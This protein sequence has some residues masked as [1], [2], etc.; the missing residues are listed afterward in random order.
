M[1]D[2]QAPHEHTPVQVP[3][4]ETPGLSGLL[5]LAGFVVVVAGLYVGREVLIP[6]TLAIL[7][8]FLIAPLA[9]L[10]RRAHFGRVP[11]VL[12]AVVLALGVIVVL[13]GLIGAQFA[14]LAEQV[15]QYESTIV[16]KVREVR[17]FA[18][19][20]MAGIADRVG[21]QLQLVTNDQTTGSRTGPAAAPAAPKPLAVQVQQAALSPIDIARSILGPVISPLSTTLIVLI[22]SVFILLQREDLRNRLIRVFGSGDLHRTTLAIDDAAGRLSRYFL[23]QVGINTIFGVVIGAGLAVIGVP[24]PLL[25]GTLSMLLRFLPY[26][27]SPLSSVG[28]LLLAA[29][30]EPNW[31]MVIWTAALYSGV[32]IVTS[33][34]VEPMVYGRSTGL[35]P[36]A[37]VVA[38]TFWTWLWGPI[39][40][41]LSTP[42]TLCLVVLGRHVKRLEFLD[43]LLGDRP[44][45]SS[46]ESFYQRI[47]AGDPDEA[48]DQ[49]EI[50]LKSCSLS[51]YYDEVVLKGLQMAA[52]DAAR[53]A[54]SGQQL[55]QVKVS[56]EELVQDLDR[57]DDVDPS[58]V[59]EEVAVSPLGEP[60]Q[61]DVPKSGTIQDEDPPSGWRSDSAVLCIAGRGP[62]DEGVATMLAQLLAKH[63]LGARM[64]PFAAVTRDHIGALAV[65]GVKMVCVSYLEISGSPA[66]LR[67][68]LH[69]LRAKVPNVPIMVGLWP[70]EELVLREERVR[71]IIGAEYYTSTLR[72]AVEACLSASKGK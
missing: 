30:V 60:K 66:H 15:P 38:A 3:P 65:S 67:Y 24:S 54:L 17:S 49:A 55:E 8:S 36:F 21:R 33:Q 70:S 57:H 20:E 28:P 58:P 59:A 64:V 39:G 18:L 48:L 11:S 56:I 45:L 51:S 41:L 2:I 5:T 37:V 69:R 1:P 46:I 71:A 34:V 14:Q 16:H 52:S 9:N 19:G 13:A 42:L 62:L 68:L 40:L 6:I 53:G 4:A 43:I 23:F 27:G 32:E 31:S 35:S 10:L 50:L 12:V 61:S 63:Q 22:F 47:L 26:L 44:A 25:W 72:E 7:L 29:A